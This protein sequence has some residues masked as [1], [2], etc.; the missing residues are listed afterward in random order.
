MENTVLTSP[1]YTAAIILAFFS[2]LNLLID[3]PPFIFHARARNIAASSLILWILLMNLSDLINALIWPN[4]NVSNWFSGTILC[5][6]EVKL[7]IGAQIGQTG[8]LICI[9][10]ELAKVLDTDNATMGRSSGEEKKR[11]IGELIMCWGLPVLLMFAHYVVQPARYAVFGLNGCTI[12][13]D[14]SWPAVVLVQMWPPLFALVDVYYS[15]LVIYRIHRYRTQFSSL[16]T[17]SNTNRSRFL[18][19]FLMALSL[20]LAFL[21]LTIYLFYKNIIVTH[22]PYSWKLVH[23]PEAWN[24]ILMVPSYGVVLIDHWIRIAT[25]IS[26]FAFFGVGKEA[27]SMYRTALVAI[28]LGKVFP[29]LKEGRSSTSQGSSSSFGSRAKAYVKEKWS[30][31][32]ATAT[33]STINTS[34]FKLGRA[35]SATPHK[36]KAWYMRLFR[37]RNQDAGSNMQLP[38]WNPQSTPQPESPV[39][40]LGSISEVGKEATA[41]ATSKAEDVMRTTSFEMEIH[42]ELGKEA[43]SGDERF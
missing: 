4:D 28:G 21:I 12:M 14:N 39:S 23:D 36:A 17:A 31:S 19:L 2:L 8:A 10:R 6:I 26:V 25:G 22:I 1:V 13:I 27:T 15:G 30:G 32:R 3:L 37:R 18:R 33:I 35:A 7:F 42:R 9:M 20:G 40:T 29:R 11:M 24:E 41:L 43:N 5:D 16:L 34:T 38:I